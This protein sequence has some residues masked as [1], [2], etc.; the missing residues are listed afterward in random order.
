M[1]IYAK[2]ARQ[3]LIDLIN[4]GNPDLPFPINEA[5][6]DFTTPEAITV[7]AEGHN[8]EIRLIAKPT[9]P[10]TGNV[11]LTYRRLNLAYLFRGIVPTV[12]KWV[13][14]S[15]SATSVTYRSTLRQLLPIYTKKYGIALDASQI[16][17]VDLR[18]Y[19][20][21]DPD[22]LFN[23]SARGDSLIFVGATQAR[24]I[25]GKRTLADLIQID[26]VEGRM[27][28]DGNGFTEGTVRKN[29]LTPLTYQTDFTMYHQENSQW[30]DYHTASFLNR[31]DTRYTSNRQRHYQESIYRNILRP[32]IF[33]AFGLTLLDPQPVYL[34]NDYDRYYTLS[35]TENG[36]I[37]LYGMNYREVSLPDANYPEANSEFYNS[38]IVIETPGDCPWGTGPI[39]LHYNK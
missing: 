12:R 3:M 32:L 38:A 7:T 25:I 29:Y 16:I 30:W 37:G 10:Y 9:S 5:D 26:E 39:F 34:G 22:R 28:P 19:H 24:W 23:I 14:N 35:P 20:G 11:V 8:T 15:G 13:E 18:E 36:E 2:T 27:Y 21:N 4:E 17:N 6:Y 1:A 33:E 31:Y